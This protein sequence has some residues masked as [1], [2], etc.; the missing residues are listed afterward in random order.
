V[1]PIFGWV[2]AALAVGA[3]WASYGWPGVALAATVI[4]FWLLIQFNRSL[5][6]LRNAGSTPVGHIDSAVMLNA[7][8]HAG[9]PMIKVVALTKS[10]GRRVSQTP[11]RWAWADA[12]G[13]EVVLD[14]ERGLCKRWV[15][16]RPAEPATE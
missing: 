11:E 8:L 2:M 14:F 13:A 16:T 10:L 7:K 9:M 3:G 15:L 4:V 5:K 6:V 1:N 12:G